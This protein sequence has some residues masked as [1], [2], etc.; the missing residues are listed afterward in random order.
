MQA[1]EIIIWH[2]IRRIKLHFRPPEISLSRNKKSPDYN[3]SNR[4]QGELASVMTGLGK[5]EPANTLSESID[6]GLYNGESKTLTK[7]NSLI[8]SVK[9]EED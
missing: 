2:Q 4:G 1:N 8:F 6:S 7:A 9:N 3:L 5:L